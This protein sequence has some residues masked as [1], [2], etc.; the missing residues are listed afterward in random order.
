GLREPGEEKIMR[1]H[2]TL[3][4]G[5]VLVSEAYRAEVEARDDLSI[6]EEA[7]PMPF[8]ASGDLP[9]HF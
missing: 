1:I 8:D 9:L 5:E 6:V 2:N 4:L 3:D 7:T